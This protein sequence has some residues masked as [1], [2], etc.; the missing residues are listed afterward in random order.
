MKYIK[1]QRLKSQPIQ[2]RTSGSTFK[3]P[4]KFYAAKLIDEAG[5]KGMFYGNAYVSEKHSN[6]LINNG[7]ASASDIE[8]L[9]KKI[10]E[11]VFNKFNIKLEWEVK[12]IGE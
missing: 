10:I 12:I 2:N 7:N 3:N 11:K 6:F 5:C 8:N 4:K 1:N 9:G